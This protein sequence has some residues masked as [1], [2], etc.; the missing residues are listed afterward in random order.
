MQSLSRLIPAP[1]PDETAARIKE[2]SMDIFR[3]LDCKGVVRIDFMLD[4]EDGGLYVGEIN[5]IPGSLAFYLWEPVGLPFGKLL[6][7]MIRYALT[8]AADRRESVFSYKSDILKNQKL[9][10][11]KGK[12]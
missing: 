5:T 3:A 12:G 1:I 6:D 2:L 11:V 4:G 8:A 7:E 10:G 9:G